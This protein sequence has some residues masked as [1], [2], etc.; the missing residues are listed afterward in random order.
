VQQLD[1]V[2]ASRVRIV[3]AGDTER[4]R[5]ERDLHDGIQQRLLA[6][7]LALRRAA[8]TQSHDPGAAA[9]LERGAEEALGVVSDVRVLA[10]G[11]HPAVLTEAG[12]GAALRALADRSLVPVRVDLELDGGIGASAAA[13]GYF[14]ASE[15]LAN[16]AKHA[17]ASSVTLTAVEQ[18]GWLH[19]EVSDDGRGG[20]DPAG[21][22]LRGLDDRVNAIGG[23]LLVSSQPNGGTTVAATIPLP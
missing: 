21:S 22:G 2:R 7:A 4:R 16:V 8:T 11:V 13:T 18:D 5:I 1:E 17:A 12:L 10:Q 15:A 23:T 20:A 6:L 14:V 9:A 19:L 3:E